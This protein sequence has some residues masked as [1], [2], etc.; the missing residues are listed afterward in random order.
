[1]IVDLH[2]EETLIFHDEPQLFSATDQIGGY[3]ICLAVDDTPQ[4]IAVAISYA[5]LQELKLG[6]IDL[7]SIFSSPEL[8]VWFKVVLAEKIKLIGELMPAGEKIPLDWLPIKGEY[9]PTMPKLRPEAFEGVKISI[10]A[11]EAKMNPTLLRQYVAGIKQPSYDQAL[12]IQ[13]ALHRVAQRLLDS[14]FV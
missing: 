8:G 6:K 11:K 7:W 14:Q 1:M 13:E 9:L 10:V 12:R 5:R 4:Y 3:Y 2:L